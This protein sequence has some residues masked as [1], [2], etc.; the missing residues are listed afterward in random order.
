MLGSLQSAKGRQ[1]SWLG[2]EVPRW[3]D[4]WGLSP[5]TA[6]ATFLTQYGLPGVTS[7]PVHPHSMQ[8]KCHLILAP[9]LAPQ[10]L[11]P[12]AP[13][14]WRPFLPVP[15][16][17]ELHLVLA[18]FRPLELAPTHSNWPL[19]LAKPVCTAVSLFSCPRATT[20]PVAWQLSQVRRWDKRLSR[21]THLLQEWGK[22]PR[23][24]AKDRDRDWQACLGHRTL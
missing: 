3:P 11:T 17:A 5:G 8:E 7:G 18:P 10:G 15:W 14:S 2:S 21:A 4:S 19:G 22:L 20:F 12:A 9:K 6:K 13:S 16:P 24:V 1:R 23:E